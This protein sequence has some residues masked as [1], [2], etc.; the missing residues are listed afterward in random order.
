MNTT[1]VQIPVHKDIEY[2]GGIGGF[3]SP[4]NPY[5]IA[6]VYQQNGRNFVIKGGQIDVDREVARVVTGPAIVHRT[7]YKNGKATTETPKIINVKRKLYFYPPSKVDRLG[8]KHPRYTIRLIAGKGEKVV[9]KRQDGCPYS[10]VHYMKR[11]P[12]GWIKELDQ[13]C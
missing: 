12:R 4:S 2:T 8:H 1:T 7:F 11:I 9:A 6:F 10:F 5:T 13:F 3:M